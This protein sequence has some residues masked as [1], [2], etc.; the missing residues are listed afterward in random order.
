[1]AE[2]RTHNYGL[3]AAELVRPSGEVHRI[4]PAVNEVVITAGPPFRMLQLGLN[5][6]GRQGPL[7]TGDGLIVSTPLGSTAY[8]LSAGGPIVSPM[9][10]VWSMTPIAAFSLSFRPIVISSHG[11]LEVNVQR[12]NGDD[13]CPGTTIVID[14]QVQKRVGTG[15]R[16]VL[17]RHDRE[18]R[19]VSNASADYWSRLISKLGW[20]A[21]P[22]V[23]HS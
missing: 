12:A 3:I 1:D 15:D 14:G 21:P 6:N 11:R 17:T 16:L 2:L 10:D 5:I 8:N 13:G 4:G 20:A 9:V 18:I 19:F 7:L 22:R 23:R